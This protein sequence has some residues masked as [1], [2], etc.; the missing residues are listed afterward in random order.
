[1]HESDETVTDDEMPMT[2]QLESGRRKDEQSS[3]KAFGH[4]LAIGE[5]ALFLMGLIAN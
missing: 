2:T 3:K 5:L 1:M 4:F